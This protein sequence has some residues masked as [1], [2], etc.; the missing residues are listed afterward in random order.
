MTAGASRSP[1]AAGAGRARSVS[2]PPPSRCSRCRSWR[3]RPS[4]RPSVS[5]P[6]TRWSRSRATATASRPA[7]RRRPSPSGPGSATCTWRSTRRPAGGSRGTAAPRTAPARSS[8]APEH[9]RLLEQ[10]VLDAFTTTKACPRKPNRPPGERAL[11]EAARLRG[12]DPGGVVVDLDQ[13]ARIAKVAGRDEQARQLPGAPR[14]ISPI[15]SSPR[16]PST[17]PPRSSRPRRTSP[18]TR[19]SCTT[20]SRSRSTRPSSAGSPAGCGSPG[21][22]R[23]RRWRSSTSPPNPAS[24]ARSSTSSRRCGSSR[25]RPT[26]C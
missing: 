4:T 2:S 20:C 17:S 18:A 22:R 25:R 11:A 23:P 10:A 15:S 3:S 9:A 14:A 7:T 21:S 26:C 24:T 19:S 12:Q 5:S 13:Y 16:S 1:T 8:A 6:T